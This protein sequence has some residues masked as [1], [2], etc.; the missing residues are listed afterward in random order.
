MQ[1]HAPAI[2]ERDEALGAAVVERLVGAVEDETFE[3]DAV[4][5]VGGDKG[6]AAGELQR[7]RASGAD[8]TGARAQLQRADA[9]ASGGQLER[10]PAAGGSVERGLQHRALIDGAAGD[11]VEAASARARARASAGR[12]PAVAPPAAKP[13]ARPAESTLRRSSV[14]AG[15]LVG[16][17]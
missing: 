6:A 11:E 5:L 17:C 10:R 16:A 2:A 12:A 13:A 8:E 7:R 3:Q 14:I 1:T 9:I 4:G 15:N